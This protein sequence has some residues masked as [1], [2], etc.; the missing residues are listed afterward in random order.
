MQLQTW[1]IQIFRVIGHVQPTQNQP[2]AIGVLWL[3]SRFATCRKEPLQTFVFEASDHR[4]NVTLR[5]TSCKNAMA[6]TGY[7]NQQ[8][9]VHK[10]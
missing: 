6:E 9:A 3:N 2:Q 4:L 10:R 8:F 5:V 1:K 7:L